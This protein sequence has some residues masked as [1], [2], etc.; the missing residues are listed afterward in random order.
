MEYNFKDMS[1][2]ELFRLESESK[3]T[4]EVM[5]T[6]MVSTIQIEELQNELN[7]IADEKR[8]RGIR[9]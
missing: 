9:E 7:C 3:R 2:I 5:L 4:L 1:D 8:R 6:R